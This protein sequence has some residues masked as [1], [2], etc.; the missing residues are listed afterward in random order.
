MIEKIDV[1]GVE[2]DE[3]TIEKIRSRIALKNYKSDTSLRVVLC[4]SVSSE[5]TPNAQRICEAIDCLYSL[6]V[7]DETLP[8]LDEDSLAQDV[9]VRG[10][11][12]RTLL[13]TIREGSEEE[14]KTAVLALR[15]GLSALDDKPII[16]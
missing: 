14:R 16:L 8:T 9:S 11:F 12:Y 5:Y 10:E 2:T 7:K 13:K 1:M 15:L 6:D 4:G 3:E